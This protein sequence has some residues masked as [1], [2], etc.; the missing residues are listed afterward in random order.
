VVMIRRKSAADDRAGRHEVNGELTSDR[1]VLE[2]GDALWRE[3]KR[4]DVAILAGF[5]RGERG[6]RPD[7]QAEIETN[8]VD[9]AGADACAGQNEQT[10]LGQEIAKLWGAGQV[11]ERTRPRSMPQGPIYS[12]DQIKNFYELHRKGK[13]I[14]REDEWNRLEW[15]IIRAGAEGRILGG[16][17]PQGK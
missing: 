16:L 1:R 7:R 6:D 17:A 11:L 12:R 15:E 5:A 13:F 8:T 4:E 14:G 10:V 3:Q 2:V 9:M